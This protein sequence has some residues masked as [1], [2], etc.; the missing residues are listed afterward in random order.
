LP[1]PVQLRLICTLNYHNSGY[2]NSSLHLQSSRAHELARPRSRV[3]LHS[4]R[5]C[6]NWL[7]TQCSFLCATDI[8]FFWIAGDS[9]CL[10]ESTCIYDVIQYKM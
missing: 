6:D 3:R 4:T 1:L 10:Q 5:N 9:D 2:T 7:L 8:Y